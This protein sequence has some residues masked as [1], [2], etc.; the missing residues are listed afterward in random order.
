MSDSNISLS[1]HQKKTLPVPFSLLR[2][3]ATGM[4]HRSHET[5]AHDTPSV[6]REGSQRHCSNVLHV[7]CICMF[8]KSPKKKKK[9]G[10]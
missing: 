2:F 5:S 1:F 6:L 3:S 7:N 8:A 10:E 9:R 4:S